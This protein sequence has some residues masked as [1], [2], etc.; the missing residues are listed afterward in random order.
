MIIGSKDFVNEAFASAREIFR[1]EKRRSSENAGGR[2]RSGRNA[3]ECEGFTGA[4]VMGS[5]GTSG[6]QPLLVS[7]LN[8]VTENLVDRSDAFP[9]AA[10]ALV[11][12]PNNI[13]QGTPD[14]FGGMFENF[15]IGIG[16]QSGKDAPFVAVKISAVKP[17]AFFCPFIPLV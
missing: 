9:W 13:A 14:F 1:E 5:E 11:F 10:F 6:M 15:P 7:Y 3:V 16:F 12:F 8:I 4:G 2:E 17:F